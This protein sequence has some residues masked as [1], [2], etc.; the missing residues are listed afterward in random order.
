MHCCGMSEQ[1][2]SMMD[3]Q[4]DGK[5]KHTPVDFTCGLQSN[6]WWKGPGAMLALE[7]QQQEED[8]RSDG[9]RMSLSLSLSLLLVGY[10]WT[11]T[12]AS[13]EE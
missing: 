2:S 12:L 6:E 1:A 7:K 4:R 13:L 10:Y 3:S 5:G 8:G 11:G 9:G